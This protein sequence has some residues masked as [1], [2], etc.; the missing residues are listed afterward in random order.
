MQ[1]TQAFSTHSFQHVGEAERWVRGSLRYSDAAASNSTWAALKKESRAQVGEDLWLY[2]NWFFGMTNGVILESG[3]LDGDLL[4]TSRMFE[5][6]N[7]KSVHIGTRHGFYCLVSLICFSEADPENFSRLKVNRPNSININGGLCSDARILHYI[8]RGPPTIR[9]FVE[10][11]D[12]AFLKHWHG[13][14]VNN[15]AAVNDLPTIPCLPLKYLLKLLQLNHIDIW[16][17][18]VEGAEMSVLQGVDFEK[19]DFSTIVMEWYVSTF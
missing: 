5:L 6:L 11:M 18:D 19:V 3:A 10:F 4:S 7:W 17:L 2:E 14:L 15:S 16:V 8:N 12:P 13:K 1:L 9:G